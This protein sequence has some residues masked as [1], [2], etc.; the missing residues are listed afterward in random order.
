MDRG[1]AA[2]APVGSFRPAADARLAVVAGGGGGSSFGGSGVGLFGNLHGVT[3]GDDVVDRDPRLAAVP[4]MEGVAA[5][6]DLGCGCIWY[7]VDEFFTQQHSLA[8]RGLLHP[9]RA[10]GSC[11]VRSLRGLR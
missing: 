9:R 1:H 3:D 11:G 5:D 6:S 7:L 10:F 4:F 8:G 2:H